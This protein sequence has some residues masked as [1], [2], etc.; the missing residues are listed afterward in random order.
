MVLACYTSYTYHIFYRLLHYYQQIPLLITILLLPIVFTTAAFFLQMPAQKKVRPS[1][2]TA[3]ILIGTLTMVLL[4]FMIIFTNVWGYVEP[5]SPLLFRNKFWLPFLLITGAIMLLVFFRK[6]IAGEKPA[7]GKS[8]ASAVLPVALAACFLLTAGFAWWTTR[9]HP[10]A[11]DR[12][13]LTVM[14]YNIQ[15]ANDEDAE[16][17]YL[18]QLAIIREIDPDILA[19]Q[20][21]H[22]A[23]SDIAMMAFADALLAHSQGLERVIALGDYN[24]RH[25]EEAYQRIAAVYH[26]VPGSEG[27]IDHIF[28]S[29]DLQMINPVYIP[30]PASATDHPL[31]YATIRWD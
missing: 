7:A 17:S 31:L 11:P 23:G 14:T 22:P 26:N 24:L 12:T 1:A 25:T 13:S 30:A 20:E 19:L 21:I 10:A 27:H 18:R 6:S 29:Y 28:L 5:V 9:T 15:Q 8:I 4:I 2:F 3:G 16:R